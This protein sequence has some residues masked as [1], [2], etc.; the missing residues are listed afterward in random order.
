M[1]RAITQMIHDLMGVIPKKADILTDQEV[2][3]EVEDHPL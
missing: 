1:S 2:D 3:L